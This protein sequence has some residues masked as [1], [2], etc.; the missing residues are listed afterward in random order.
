MALVWGEKGPREP[1][2]RRLRLEDAARAQALSWAVGWGH[3]VEDWARLIV[4][5]GRGCFCIAQG[6]RLIATAIA[7]GYGQDRAWIGMVITHPDCQRQGYG[8]QVTL[9]AL[10][11]LQSQGV[12]HIMLDAAAAGR[13]LYEKMGFR[14]LYHIEMWTGRAS[15]YLGP[16]A[17]PLRRSDLEG[18]VALD[19]QVFG[20]SR[21]RIIRRLATD[22]PRLGWVDEEDGEIVGFALAQTKAPNLVHIGPWVH[23]S[24]WGAEKL[25]RTA[26][27]ALIG[28]QVRVDIPDHNAQATVFAHNHDLRY[29]RRS[30]RMIYG[31]APPPEA[32]IHYQYGI[33]SPATG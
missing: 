15:D 28:R 24:P 25:L 13:P 22:F 16:R 27:G 8:R 1:V 12:A 20:V 33:A 32:I 11:Y 2:L 26:L 21:G 17:R 23:R 4:W 10:E 18:V 7:M 29:Q 6:E 19:G 30:T 14:P 31:D 9:A 3:T 5:G